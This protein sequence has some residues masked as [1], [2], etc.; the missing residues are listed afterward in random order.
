[1]D[2]DWGG[3]GEGVDSGR[4]EGGMRRKEYRKDRWKEDKQ[5]R[6]KTGRKKGRQVFRRGSNDLVS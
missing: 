2:W 6:Q 3:K 1:M 5:S 4:Q